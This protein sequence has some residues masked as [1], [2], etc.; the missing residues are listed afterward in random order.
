[1]TRKHNAIEGSVQRVAVQVLQGMQCS[2]GRTM[3]H[4]CWLQYEVVSCVLTSSVYFIFCDANSC[5]QLPWNQ[6]ISKIVT[7]WKK[8]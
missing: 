8:I 6:H 7:H 2:I 1:M 4:L 3:L 5:L